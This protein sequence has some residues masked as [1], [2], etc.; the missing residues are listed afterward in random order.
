MSKLKNISGFP[1]WLPE[2]KIVEDRIIGI[3]RRIY[4]SY[5][6]TPIE[7]PA[8]ELLSTLTSKGEI[9]KEIYVVKRLHAP[10]KEEA[11][12]ALHYDLT[13][14]FAR[15]V[16]QHFS[17]LSFPFRRYQCQKSWRGERAQKGRFRE[18]YQFDLDI[19]GRDTLPLAA[20][21]EVISAMDQV[22]RTLDVGKHVMRV[23]NR[24]V[25]LGIYTSLGLSAEQAKGAITAVDK[26]AKIGRAGVL[27]ELTEKITL[28]QNQ[29]ERITDLAEVRIPPSDVEYILSNL[30]VDNKLF[31]QGK[32]EL[33]ELI[34]LLPLVAQSNI[35]IDLS[36]AR[37]LDYYTGTI[38]EVQMVDYPEFGTLAG[39]GRYDDLASEFINK[40][41]PGVGMTFG[42]TRF[43]DLVFNHNLLAVSEKTPVKVLVAVP[44]EE[45]RPACNSLA[46]E[47][48]DAGVAC[49]V[50][51]GSQRIGKQIEYAD[52]RG[53]PF[54]AFRNVEDETVEIKDL[55]KKEQYKINVPDWCAENFRR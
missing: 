38:V 41:L 6:F 7:T 49:E 1:E 30:D 55:T 48:R 22:F 53:I 4:Q 26:I 12:L 43:L 44:S 16:A 34:S 37:G 23:N 45:Q 31:K 25:L 10:E 18:F 9:D 28:D 17:K 11:A 21:A 50:F 15:Y 33:V 42:L 5:G 40:K 47:F 13:V 51:L 24:K 52:A 32:D 20:D 54:V 14:P 35:Q 2:Q 29:A 27:K 8:V 19:I 39:G 46:S 36:L 3:I